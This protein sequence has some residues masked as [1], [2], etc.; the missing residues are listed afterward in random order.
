MEIHIKTAYDGKYI[1]V[2]RK[3]SFKKQHMMVKTLM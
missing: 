3:S 2:D 1:K